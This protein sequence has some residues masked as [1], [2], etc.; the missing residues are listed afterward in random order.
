MAV[1]TNG[2]IYHCVV[3]CKKDRSFSVKGVSKQLSQNYPCLKD[4]GAT[5]AT[6]YAR[7]KTVYDKVVKLNSNRQHVAKEKFMADTF[8]LP[9]KASSHLVN[10]SLTELSTDSIDL[11][12]T[13]AAAVAENHSLK[14]TVDD[15]EMENDVIEA[16]YERLLSVL[17]SITNKLL[18]LHTDRD[19]L[20]ET[21]TKLR[22]DY[23]K[24]SEL[25]EQTQSTLIKLKTKQNS[26][27][28]RNVNKKLK[29]RDE[30]I[31]NLKTTNAQKEEEV[32]RLKQIVDTDREATA[33][34][35]ETLQTKCRELQAAKEVVDKLKGEKIKLQ[36]SLSYFRQKTKCDSDNP[37]LMNDLQQ[38]VE[39]LQKDKAELEQLSDIL[40]D[41]DI[42]TFCDGKY[43]PE[44][45]EVVMELL[46]LNVSMNAVNKVITTVLSK[47]AKKNI[48]RLPSNAL[49]STLLVEAKHIA[50]TQV[51]EA[52]LSSPQTCLHQ[53]GTSKFH[54]H[55]QG[56]QVTLPS[57]Q[58]MT[59][60]MHQMPGSTTND[61]MKSFEDSICYLAEAVTGNSSDK[62]DVVA[63]LIMSINSTMSDQGPTIGTFNR[64][65]KVLLKSY[66]QQ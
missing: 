23:E 12:A 45:R 8:S 54:K 55:Y 6:L 10:S 20:H 59:L 15:L 13:A 29:R 66:F 47:L 48:G 53:D 24:N 32:E 9:M 37:S 34:V 50:A 17:N 42:I 22:K 44:I 31:S 61:V 4:G 64:Q 58:T 33:A 5:D 11:A 65:I 18:E 21:I 2:D 51:A 43:V 56:Y 39:R 14:R 19:D 40:E 25:L 28:I 36:K 1:V 3:Q 60:G 35:K 52:M 16:E 63:K 46:S 41:K 38:Q 57:G 30:T 62:E 26:V 49:K 7:G 27:N